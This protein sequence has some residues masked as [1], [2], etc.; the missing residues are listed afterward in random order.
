MSAGMRWG[1]ASIRATLRHAAL[2]GNEE[3]VV[4]TAE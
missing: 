1:K 4:P 2:L 3:T